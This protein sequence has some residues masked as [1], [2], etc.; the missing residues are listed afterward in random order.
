MEGDGIRIL[1]TSRH[2]NKL[3]PGHLR[4]NRF[5]I[6][7]REVAPHAAT[8]TPALIGRIREQG[9][10]NY[11]GTQRFG[12]GAETLTLGL[13]LLRGEK[14]QRLSPFLRKL[15]LSA[16]QSALFNHY[17]ALRLS[18][19]LLQ[20]V[21]SGDVMAKVPFGG[22]FVAED[23]VREQARF[24]AREIVSAGPIFGRKMFP[25]AADAAARERA[26]LANAGLTPASFS[27]FGKLLQGTRR[28]NLVYVT[29]LSAAMQAA[30]ARLTFTLPAGSYATTLLRELMKSD[31]A[32]AAESAESA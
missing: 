18:D 32:A 11:Y 7:I 30:A 25:A 26:V 22:M 31:D 2:T 1:K 20:R 5:S 17:L 19:G 9:L 8:I 3:R 12:R 24:D 10:P 14:T 28:H 15:A 13:A 23:V 29:D 21:L 27:G 4:G 6:L 16:V